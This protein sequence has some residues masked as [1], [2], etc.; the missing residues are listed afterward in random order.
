MRPSSVCYPAALAGFV[1]LAGCGRKADPD[2]LAKG[3]LSDTEAVASEAQAKVVEAGDDMADRLISILRDEHQRAKHLRI[4]KAFAEMQKRETLKDFKI[5]K[6]AGVLGDVLRDK[7]TAREAR[8]E[9]ARALGGFKAPTA[10]RPLIAVISSE[11]KELAEASTASLTQLGALAVEPLVAV[12]DDADTP[13]DQ[14]EAVI[15]ALDKVSET[16]AEKLKSEDAAE[17]QK[18]VQLLGKTGSKAAR[19]HIERVLQDAD[20]KVRT[21]VVTALSAKPTEEELDVLARLAAD[22]DQPVAIEAMVALA[23]A[24]DP[25]AIGLLTSVIAFNQSGSAGFKDAKHR[26]RAVEATAALGDPGAI[27]VLSQSLLKDDEVK[28]RRAAALAI[29]SFGDK[30][31]KDALLEAIRVKDQD[32]KVL[33]VCSRALGKI[34]VQEGV[35]Q[36]VALLDSKDSTVR[37][38]AIQALGDV[39]APAVDALIGCLGDEKSTSAR[40]S[41]ACE[42]LGRIGSA[43]AVD[44]LA[45]FIRRPLPQTRERTA[46]EEKAAKELFVRGEE[47]HIAAVQA[48]CRIGD[49]RGIKPI[50]D[51][52]AARPER[53]RSFAEW[54]LNQFREKAPDDLVE[55]LAGQL[56]GP[57]DWSFQPEDIRDLARLAEKVRNPDDPFAGFVRTKL[58]KATQDALAQVAKPE[59]DKTGTPEEKLAA[60]AAR[61]MPVRKAVAEELSAVLAGPAFYSEALFVGVWLPRQTR[62]LAAGGLEGDDLKRIHRTL[63]ER[64]FPAEIYAHP[65]PAA[66]AAAARILGG[67][68]LRAITI[69]LQGPAAPARVIRGLDG[70]GRERVISAL[71]P[72]LESQAILF[73]PEVAI[74]ACASVARLVAAGA[75]LDDKTLQRLEALAER[76][77]ELEDPAQEDELRGACVDALGYR[78]QPEPL[79]VLVRLLTSEQDPRLRFRVT[80]ALGCILQ[81]AGPEEAEMPSELELLAAVATNDEKL[82]TGID[83]IDRIQRQAVLR[84]GETANMGAIPPVLHVLKGSKPG[85]ELYEAASLAYL[86]IT[87]R[88]FESGD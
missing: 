76:T 47:P 41:S 7:E 37:I 51:L 56:A 29:E 67:M 88:K 10:V 16:L 77:P 25:R 64:A 5:N 42:A 17:R 44:A 6:V 62:T 48:L 31:D 35:R 13:A 70:E 36:L 74:Q 66:A 73:Q 79:P 2:E 38:P 63:L 19:L 28:V 24:K 72:L 18:A 78:A 69:T 85:S 9:I 11:D 86:R 57:G 45:A 20:P 15:R 60:Q 4:V 46:D 58:S 71:V 40:Q 34:G 49:P 33:L 83:S 3:I 81:G 82:T 87:G 80:A 43:D 8:L 27:G 75:D 84:L 39:G 65:Y 12:R 30:A 26:V 55:A 23:T 50:A 14:R 1:L 61:E 21:E 54:A 52:L 59:E 53:L 22:A 68:S 32:D